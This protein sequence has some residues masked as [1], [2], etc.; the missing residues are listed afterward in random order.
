MDNPLDCP[1][2]VR[3]NCFECASILLSNVL[4][5]VALHQELHDPMLQRAKRRAFNAGIQREIR[6]DNSL[7]EWKHT[8]ALCRRYRILFWIVRSILPAST[9]DEL[10]HHTGLAERKIVPRMDTAAFMHGIK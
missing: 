7:V 5:G 4:L 1:T 3:V 8:G 6:T 2:Q 9:A 10:H